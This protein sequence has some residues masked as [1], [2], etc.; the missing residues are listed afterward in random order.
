MKIDYN[1]IEERNAFFATDDELYWEDI[2]NPNNIPY[3]EDVIDVCKFAEDIWISYCDWCNETYVDVDEE[4]D[5]TVDEE[6][7]WSD[8]QYDF[9]ANDYLIKE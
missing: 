5:V 7:W 6:A 8:V 3:D 1:D 9:D 2:N 4:E